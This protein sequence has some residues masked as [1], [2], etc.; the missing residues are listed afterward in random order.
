M[1]QFPVHPPYP[2]V[3]A[4]MKGAQRVAQP[5]IY[6]HSNPQGPRQPAYTGTY[7]GEHAATFAEA[8]GARRQEGE[9]EWVSCGQRRSDTSR[10]RL[11]GKADAQGGKGGCGSPHYRGRQVTSTVGGS[12]VIRATFAPQELAYVSV[13]PRPLKYGIT[14]EPVQ[15][16]PPR[17]LLET[18]SFALR[19][20]PEQSN[21]SNMCMMY[22][23]SEMRRAGA[24][25]GHAGPPR[26]RGG[27]TRTV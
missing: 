14:V 22:N 7:R 17:P 26:G 12:I 23:P 6:P 1:T 21:P 4:A 13:L 15:P 18:T 5:K 27:W 20:G 24:G 8:A 3:M 11:T 2:R 19:T 10:P 9:A 16:P 25:S